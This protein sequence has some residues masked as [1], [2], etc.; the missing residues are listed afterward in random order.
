VS[1]GG[2]DD[3]ISS[4]VRRQRNPASLNLIV[5][6]LGA[7]SEHVSTNRV[8][9]LWKERTLVIRRFQPAKCFACCRWRVFFSRPA[10]DILCCSHCSVLHGQVNNQPIY[11]FQ[12]PGFAPDR[13]NARRIF[14]RLRWAGLS[15]WSV[16]L[17]KVRPCVSFYRRVRPSSAHNNRFERSR[18]A[19]SVS[20]GGIDDWDKLPSSSVAAA[21]RRSTSS[22][23][24]CSSGQ[25]RSIVYSR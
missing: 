11:E 15:I 16:A 12:S 17:S 4:Y 13:G 18:V 14:Y 19:S 22:L 3:E 2:V 5:M 8:F 24:P 25:L 21:P 6:R 1:Q 10:S 9:W 23:E 7:G 20:P